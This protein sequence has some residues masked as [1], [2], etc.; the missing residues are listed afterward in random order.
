MYR[1]EHEEARR[2]GELNGATRNTLTASSPYSPTR[3]S[4]YNNPYHPPPPTAPHIPEPYTYPTSVVEPPKYYNGAYTTPAA[5][6]PYPPRSPASHAHPRRSSLTQSPRM[7]T[8]AS[9]PHVRHNGVVVIGGSPAAIP[10]P[11]ATTPGRPADPMAM[12][13]ILS[14]ADPLPKPTPPPNVPKPR[15]PAR[16][17]VAASLEFPP[18]E[19]PTANPRRARRS[20][21]S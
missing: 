3:A 15:K 6:A 21:N 1:H 19:R 7:A 18:N 4:P 2:D 13:S 14:S 10:P 5:A 9:P 8:M 17:S 16:Q 11:V 20:R 12:S